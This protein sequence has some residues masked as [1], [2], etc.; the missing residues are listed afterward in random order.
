MTKYILRC[1][2][3]NH[4]TKEDAYYVECPLCGG[5]LDVEFPTP[6]AMITDEAFSSIFKFH[7]VMPYDPVSENIESFENLQETPIIHAE[8][9]SKK[10]GI[11][12]FFKDET[13]MPSGTWKDRE[14]FVSIHRLL[15]NKL[16]DLVIF[17]SG[18]T[19][20]SLARSASIIKGP[21]LHIVV[22]AASR[23][24]IQTY[25]Q[26]F[27][28]DFVKTH[29]FTGSNDECIQEAAKF[30]AEKGYQIEGGFSN[31]ARREGLKLLA[32]EVISGW[33]KTADWYVQ[34]VAGG[35]GIYSYYKAYR[36]IGMTEKCPRLLGVQADICS[37][38][39]NA[40]RADAAILEE[41]YIPQ[42][43]LPSDFVRVLRTRK[44][45][46]SYP[47]LK[48]I[49]DKTRGRFESVSDHQIYDALRLFYT[50]EYYQNI[51]RRTGKLVGLE[52]ATALAGIAKG[53]NA[54]YIA[55]DET[56]LL[57]VSGSAKKGDIKMEWI[58]DLL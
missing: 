17:S 31:Y 45:T 8:R 57:N 50:D 49:M 39:V 53:I 48:K 38:M 26:F 2:A 6:P 40:W 20:T 16:S 55:H 56:V 18:N 11:S 42:Q 28:E 27:D 46:D 5:F 41:Q 30:A 33:E 36:D 51:Y 4:S 23:E 35:I 14:G 47:I 19:A 24:R 21:R 22:P 7:P 29:Y 9:L 44:P 10:L 12:L 13:A 25:K 15:K 3:C 34:P 37:P 32:L 43:V 54:G 58:A 1:A 52:P